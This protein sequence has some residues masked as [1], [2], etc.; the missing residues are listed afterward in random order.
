MGKPVTPLF[1]KMEVL[2]KPGTTFGK[3]STPFRKLGTH[4]GRPAMTGFYDSW[5]VL[6]I[7][8]PIF[9]IRRKKKS[10]NIMEV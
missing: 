7:I 10:K 9:D 1:N 8:S 2:Q 6:H 4:I 3:P 5:R